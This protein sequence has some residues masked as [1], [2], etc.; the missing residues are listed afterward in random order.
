[1]YGYTLLPCLPYVFIPRLMICLHESYENWEKEDK[2]KH[3][4]KKHNLNRVREKK[5]ASY[6]VH[7]NTLLRGLNH[8]ISLFKYVSCQNMLTKQPTYVFEFLL[9]NFLRYWKYLG[10]WVI[11]APDGRPPGYHFWT[12]AGVEL[13]HCNQQITTFATNRFVFSRIF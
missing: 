10:C 4:I 12:L 13:N 9:D 8:R 5:K 3:W 7:T 2:K 1:M 11:N 6:I